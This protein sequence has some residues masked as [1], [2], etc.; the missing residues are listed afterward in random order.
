MDHGF[1]R[2][3]RALWLLPLALSMASVLVAD[4]PAAI[5]T[6]KLVVDYGDG[7]AKHFSAL[8]W[9]SGLTVADCLRLA[10]AHRHGIQFESKGAGATL[11]VTR[12]DDLT[13]E[14]RGKNWVYRVNEKLGEASCAIHE[15]RQGDSVLWKFEVYR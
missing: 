6:V 7:V 13:N 15:L 8:P 10:A 2:L 11:M 14:G 5:P 9:K 3:R 12:I 4:E 1:Q